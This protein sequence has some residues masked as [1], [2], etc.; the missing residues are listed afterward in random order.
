MWMNPID[1][2]FSHELSFI[3]GSQ[4]ALH[5]QAV[6]ALAGDGPITGWRNARSSRILAKP[7]NG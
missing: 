4:I 5:P 1:L 2:G 7:D 6:T 3:I